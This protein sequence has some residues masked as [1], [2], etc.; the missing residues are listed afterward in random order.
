MIARFRMDL[1]LVVA[2]KSNGFSGR[3]SSVCG[4]LLRA[5]K[6]ILGFRKTWAETETGRI[7]AQRVLAGEKL[8]RN[9]CS[10]CVWLREH[11][12]QDKNNL[13][14]RLNCYAPNTGK[15]DCY[16]VALGSYL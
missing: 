6:E 9:F 10:K 8:A 16:L 12:Y 3:I 7:A 15:Y 4:P 2:K 1:F 14:R 5:L 13:V 11:P